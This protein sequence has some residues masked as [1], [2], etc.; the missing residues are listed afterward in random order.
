MPITVNSLEQTPETQI[1]TKIADKPICC[2][3]PN[4]NKQNHLINFFKMPIKV[5]S[6]EQSAET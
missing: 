1:Q 2:V 5:N 6:L 4:N 3:Q